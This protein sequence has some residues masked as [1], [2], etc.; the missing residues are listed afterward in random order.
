MCFNKAVVACALL[1]SLHLPVFGGEIRIVTST[2]DLGDIAKNI[3]GKHVNVVSLVDGRQDIHRVDA[4]PS[5]VSKLRNADLVIVIGMELDGWMDSIIRVAGNPRTQ[6]E[7]SGY[8]DTSVRI[9]K[10]PSSVNPN[11]PSVGDVHAD[12]NPHYWLDPNNGLIIADT[13]RD[14]LIKIDPTNRAEYDQNYAKYASELTQMIGKWNRELSSIK[15]T[16]LLS[17][18]SS[19]DYLIKGFGLTNAG[20]VEVY[21]GMGALGVDLPTLK[22]K[23]ARGDYSVMLFE[24]AQ[25]EANAGLFKHLASTS[26]KMV[27]LTASVIPGTAASTYINLLNANVTVLVTA[28]QK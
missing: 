25:A 23:I 26:I 7:N 28:A 6:A 11:A 10:I 17:F 2:T 27:P 8:L 14:R 13:I 20:T 4:R 16:R 9:K 12:G 24:P 19:W 18:H 3:G 5:M 1:L 21:P 15:S 22:S